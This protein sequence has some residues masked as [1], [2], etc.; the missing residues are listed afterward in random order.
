MQGLIPLARASDYTEQAANIKSACPRTNVVPVHLAGKERKLQL[1]LGNFPTK[2]LL[3]NAILQ[4]RKHKDNDV[5]TAIDVMG[6]FVRKNP[7]ISFQENM[8]LIYEKIKEPKS[9][10]HV[11][12]ITFTSRYFKYKEC[13]SFKSLDFRGGV[14]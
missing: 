10:V 9:Q 11:M 14:R 6:M 5:K 1:Q 12:E 3:S 7:Y 4:T 8:E 13:S 2:L